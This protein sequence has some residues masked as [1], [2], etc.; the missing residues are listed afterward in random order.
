MI[1]RRRRFYAAL[2]MAIFVIEAVIALFVKD[3]FVRPYLGDALVTVLLCAFLRIFFVKGISLLPLYVFLFS[4]VIEIMQYFDYVKL[5][6]LDKITF[7]SVIMGRSFSFIDIV[8]Y[9][10]G[11]ILF[12][13]IDKAAV[14]CFND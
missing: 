6:G 8:C 2:F 7:F 10:V 13:F 4:V 14:R 11:C 5:L 1:K 12:F 9:A 3:N